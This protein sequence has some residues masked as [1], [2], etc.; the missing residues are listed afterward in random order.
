MVAGRPRTVAYSVDDMIAL[1]EEMVL[2]VSENKPIHLSI[3]YT[4]VKD[5]TDNEWDTFRKRPEFVHYYTKALKLVGYSYLDKDSTVDSKLKDRWQRVYFKDLREQEDID[6]KDKRDKELEDKK[7]LLNHSHKLSN[8]VLDTVP[9]ELKQ[10]Y[11]SLMNQISALQ[12]SSEAN[13]ADN[14][15]RR[16]NKS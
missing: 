1:G 3:W 14:S 5:I 13:K 11:L 15:K 6:V 2:W 4:Q 9:D 16:D 10:Q 8:T 7:E 12:V